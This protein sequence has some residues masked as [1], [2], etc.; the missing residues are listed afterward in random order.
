ARAKVS[1][2]VSQVAG[3][4]RSRTARSILAGNLRDEDNR[5]PRHHTC[6]QPDSRRL[7]ADVVTCPTRQEMGA[8][9]RRARQM[10][11]QSLGHGLP[12]RNRGNRSWD[13]CESYPAKGGA[14]NAPTDRRLL[15]HLLVMCGRLSLLW[16]GARMQGQQRKNEAPGGNQGVRNQGS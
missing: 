16:V 10:A 5:R 15:F 11:R 8:V 13:G 4:S 12:V 14:I 7:Q 1:R 6:C 2:G 9:F 3:E